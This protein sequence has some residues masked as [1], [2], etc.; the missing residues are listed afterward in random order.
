MYFLTPEQMDG[1]PYIDG[2]DDVRERF[3]DT[4]IPPWWD[5]D[6]QEPQPVPAQ[7]PDPVAEADEPEQPLAP[8]ECPF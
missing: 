6:E 1:H 3:G 2:Y 4:A 5:D 7:A 8:G